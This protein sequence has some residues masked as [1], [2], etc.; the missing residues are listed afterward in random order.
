MLLAGLGLSV[1]VEDARRP[2]KT[3]PADHVLT[4]EPAAGQIVRRQRAVRVRLS[5]GLRA[6]LRCRS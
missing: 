5:D 4:Q 6:G 1:R 2:D 3:V